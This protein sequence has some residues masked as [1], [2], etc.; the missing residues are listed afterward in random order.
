MNGL[1]A[2]IQSELRRCMP[3]PTRTRLNL[4]AQASKQIESAQAILGE[5]SPV[6]GTHTG[7]GTVGLAWMAGI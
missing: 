7:P 1:E 4:L 2:A 5:V 3:T 6:I